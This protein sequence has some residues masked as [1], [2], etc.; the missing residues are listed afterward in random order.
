MKLRKLIYENVPFFL[1]V[2][3][4]I[5][6]I[7]FLYVP[8]LMICV[9]GMSSLSTSF[10]APFMTWLYGCVFFRSCALALS[11]ALVCLIVAY[12]V[13]YWLAMHEGPWRKIL[14]FLLFI[15]FW[16][17]FLLHVYAW[18][19]LL[20][21]Q[22]LVNVVLQSLGLISEPLHIVHT[23]FATLLLMVYCYMPF[24]ILPLYSSLEKFDPY[25]QEA[26]FDLGATWWQT[27]WRVVIPM[28]LPGI[29]TGFFL[30][31]VPAFGEF[32]I[33]ELVGGDKVMY[34]GSVIA[35][36]VLQAKTAALGASF[37]LFSSVVLLVLLAGLYL[38]FNRFNTASHE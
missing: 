21:R 27:L 35:H 6:Q 38:L 7:F 9:V 22:G 19:F 4:L 3:A 34:V 24:M 15:P 30:V 37:T 33:P 17:N 31:F 10:V 36:L 16:T 13:A 23:T 18:M 25:L 28:S 12:P 20:D 5:W 14:L 1:G 11:T 32:V 8:L 26:S 2:P 29:R